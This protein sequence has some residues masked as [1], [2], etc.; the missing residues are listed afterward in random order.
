MGHFNLNWCP[1]ASSEMTLYTFG[2]WARK[3]SEAMFLLR[4]MWLDESLDPFYGN[5]PHFP[6]PHTHSSSSPH[7][8]LLR[9]C[10]L[11]RIPMLLWQHFSSSWT[12]LF[13]SF[14]PAFSFLICVVKYVPWVISSF[15]PF[16]CIWR[17]WF[18]LVN[19]SAFIPVF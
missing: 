7:V 16:L 12:I 18:W 17:S 9:N 15:S 8:F 13:H 2:A 4:S 19:L 14:W 1:S 11:C 10:L 6:E 5:I 3:V